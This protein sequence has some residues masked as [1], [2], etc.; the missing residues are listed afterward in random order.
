MRFLM[1]ALRWLLGIAVAVLGVAV[2]AL[3]VFRWQAHERETRLSAEAAPPSGRY[4]RADD[5][6][7]FV[8]EEGPADAPAVV[9]IHGTGAWSETWRETL[10]A[11]AKAGFR[12]IA[13]DL[14]PFGY[15]QRPA[16]QRY[17]RP[18]QAKRIIGVLDTLKLK[19]VI[20]VGHSFGAGPTLEATFTAPDRVR[21]LVL[22]DAALGLQVSDGESNG[23]LQ[24]L[25]G[26]RPLRD[27]LVATFL[28]NPQFTKRLLQAFIA[29]PALATDARTALY[30]QP[31]NVAGTTPSVGAWLPALLTPASGARSSQ[32]P[33]Y[34]SLT[35]PVHIIWGARDTVTP[36]QQGEHIKKITPGAEL[37]V[38]RNVGHIPQLEDPAQFNEVLLRF[39]MPYLKSP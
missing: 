1:K 35:M 17:E 36:L 38:M 13:I 11:V 32:I 19:Q 9:F 37:A 8:Q 29:D 23:V 20:L 18:D 5:I 30:Q 31:L 7:M 6:N 34:Q 33:A 14:P 22:V 15:S 39:L 26:V 25:L 21:A 2:V 27:S 10:K 4:A 24:Q 16:T 3:A 12:A 28:T